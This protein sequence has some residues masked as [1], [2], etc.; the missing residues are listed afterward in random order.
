MR[1][2]ILLV[3][4][5]AALPAGAFP[6]LECPFGVGVVWLAPHETAGFQWNSPIKPNG[7]PCVK[8]IVIEPYNPAWWYVG[9]QSGLYVTKNSGETWIKPLTGNVGALLITRPG[10]TSVIYAG[11]GTSLYRS[12]NSGFTWTNIKTFSHTVSSLL[13]FQNKLYVGLA[14]STHVGLS[15]V[16]SGNLDGTSMTFKPF[17]LGHTGLIVWTLSAHAATGAIYAGTE[18]YDH[19]LPYDPPFFRTL[20]GGSSWTNVGASLPHH[21]IDSAVRPSD[22]YVYALLEAQGVYGSANQGVTWTAPDQSIGVGVELFMDPLY[23]TRLFAGRAKTQYL[24]GGIFMS[25]DAGRS[26]RLIGLEGVTVS[27]IA[28]NGLRT[29]LFVVAY[30]S[31]IYVG[32]MP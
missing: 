16:W 8:H 9:G 1:I 4:V 30:A 17:G 32:R 23:P 26:F 27:G 13:V 15:G 29:H 25:V 28:M 14:F 22:G 10:D 31:G 5:A 12:T 19:P 7:D 6:V 2:A 24:D 21:A 20:N 11:V 18:I 3:L